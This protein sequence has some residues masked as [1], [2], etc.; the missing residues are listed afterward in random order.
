MYADDTNILNSNNC[1][2]ALNKTVNGDLC[3]TI[4]WFQVNQY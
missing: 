3:N 4:K 1:Y 2:K